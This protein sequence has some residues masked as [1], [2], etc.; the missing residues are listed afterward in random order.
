MET[1]T[2]EVQT[3]SGAARARQPGYGKR[4]GTHGAGQ[5]T[6]PEKAS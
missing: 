6:G 5:W 4:G 3:N 1:E 2:M